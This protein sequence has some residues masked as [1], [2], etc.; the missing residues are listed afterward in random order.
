[1]KFHF[2][3]ILLLV[4]LGIEVDA[5]SP[6]K[7]LSRLRE[8]QMAIAARRCQLET[9]KNLLSQ[10]VSPN[11]RDRFN[12]PAIL[13]AFRCDGVKDERQ[14]KISELVKTL[15]EAGADVNIRNEFGVTP[16]LAAEIFDYINRS[17]EKEANY[18]KLTSYLLSKGADPTV[19]DIYDRNGFRHLHNADAGETREEQIWRQVIEGNINFD[20]N[21]KIFEDKGKMELAKADIRR[22]NS[23][24]FGKLKS[25]LSMAAIYYGS[26]G[27]SRVIGSAI[28]ALDQ[29]IDEEGEDLVFY[30]ARGD[31]LFLLKIIFGRTIYTKDKPPSD[32]EALQTFNS[33]LQK[34]LKKRNIDG[35]T[36]LDL[37]YPLKSFAFQS[38]A[39]LYLENPNEWDSEGLTPLLYVLR[40]KSGTYFLL[41]NEK[42]NPNMR[43]KGGIL[44]LLYA[45]EEENYEGV[46]L[47]LYGLKN[48]V[49]SIGKDSQKISFADVNLAD[50]T[51]KTA[52]M[53]AAGKGNSDIVKVLLANGANVFLQNEK[54]ET[55]L[56]LA[57]KNQH[58]SIVYRLAKLFRKASIKEF[59]R[60]SEDVKIT[61]DQTPLMTA[62]FN[63]NV[64][65]LKKLIETGADL[66]ETDSI[67]RTALFYAL[68]HDEVYAAEFLI[69]AQANV[70]HLAD[71]GISP[72]VLAAELK[73]DQIIPLLL[74]AGAKIDHQDQ[75]GKTALIHAAVSG[76]FE[77][78]DQILKENPEVNSKD[79][80][81]FSALICSLKENK[82]NNKEI[83]EALLKAGAEPNDTDEWKDNSIKIAVK[84]GQDNLFCLC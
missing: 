78:V 7:N 52:L 75:R 11:A 54:G 40:D 5:Q 71:G 34:S 1:M 23:L 80:E 53:I 45:V 46:S 36:P 27:L 70:N 60:N 69:E 20:I 47:L 50:S 41:M 73:C 32:D 62:A 16:F 33:F 35:K 51:G 9:V 58:S 63:G 66:E 17:V 59:S 84:T 28:P 25:S 19:K 4:Q 79:G 42:V 76:D 8:E 55:A 18:D 48:P 14:E 24:R 10:K 31:N 12:Q 81:G 65:Q 3:F 68:L 13:L 2:I 30:A 64:V 82:L 39:H 37:S 26:Y 44:P 43:S 22:A 83:I 77:T 61:K 56:S 67:G 49:Y 74:K 15:V 21:P 72:L 57:R 38:A 29:D 6:E